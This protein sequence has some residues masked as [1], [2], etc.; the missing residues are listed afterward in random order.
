LNIQILHSWLLEYL[1]TDA[2]ALAI[3]EKLALC[4]PSVEKVE[5]YGEDW[6][7]DIEVT[8]NRVDMMSVYGIAREAA[9]ILP[10]F[11]FKA[12]LKKISLNQQSLLKVDS[13]KTLPLTIKTEKELTNRVMAV[14]MD[15]VSVGESPEWI[16]TRLEASGIRSLN[17]IIDI[18][19]YVMTEI[20]HPTH[21]FD[22]DRIESH[23]LEFRMS[24]KGER[25]TTLDDKTYTLP[26][27]DSVIDDST[28]RIIDLPGIMGTKNSVV[29][30]KTKRII[31][32]IDNNNPLLMRATSMKL[33]IRTVAVT[34]NEKQVDPELAETAMLRGIELYR[35]ICKAEVASKLYDIYPKKPSIQLIKVSNKFISD[36]LGIEVGTKYIID[37]LEKSWFYDFP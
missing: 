21:V 33:G 23:L 12:S 2:P 16:K 37:T 22:Y 4:G 36:R 24:R 29:T 15:N 13:S 32:F 10:Q 1:E 17:S 20:G 26:G 9:A 3:G 31:F 18:T 27:G 35:K 19:N 14:V 7:Y 34:L 11:G 25:I 5:K 8:T 28:G 6:L 30:S